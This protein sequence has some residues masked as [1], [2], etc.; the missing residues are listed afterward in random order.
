M[1]HHVHSGA[2]IEGEPVAWMER[3]LVPGSQG[4][5]CVLC[6][7]RGRQGLFEK[8]V[9]WFLLGL[10]DLRV[11]LCGGIF[12]LGIVLCRVGVFPAFTFLGGVADFLVD[13]RDLEA[14]AMG[15]GGQLSFN[16]GIEC[17]RGC[18]RVCA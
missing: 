15:R 10:D 12:A 5:L 4:P 9:E 17:I 18:D 1:L 13:A 2:Q 16:F 11:F 7:V 14:E 8:G 6:R 3:Q